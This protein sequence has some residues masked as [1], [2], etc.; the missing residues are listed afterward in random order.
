[1]DR[2]KA[3]DITD[4]LKGKNINMSMAKISNY[5]TNLGC[6]HGTHK[7]GSKAFKGFKGL[8]QIETG[9]IDD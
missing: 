5:L 7:F 2:V 8:R 1:M 6:I 4:F 9:N 3:S